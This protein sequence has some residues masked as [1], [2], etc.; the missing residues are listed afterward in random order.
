MFEYYHSD[1]SLR[2]SQNSSEKLRILSGGNVG[3]GITD[4]EALLHLKG[5]NPQLVVMDTDTTEGNTS[6]TIRLANATASGQTSHYWNIKKE[7]TDL[8]FDDGQIGVGVDER[9]RIDSD[10]D[11]GIG[12]NDPN[13]RLDVTQD[14]DTDY[15]ATT[16]QR[17]SAQIIARNNTAGTNNFASI[18]LVNGGGTQAEA[19]INLIETDDYLGDITFKS[20]TGGSSWSEKL[21]I[22]S[23]LSLIHI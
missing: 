11:V 19:S 12:T 10:G 22:T 16:D 21:R 7:G 1:D 2:Y 14:R 20:R 17:S 13:G 8:V 18:S 15:D 23:A 5:A 6:A 9:L 3:I 4:P